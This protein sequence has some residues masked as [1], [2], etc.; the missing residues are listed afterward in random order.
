MHRRNLI[1]YVAALGGDVEIQV[2][3]RDRVVRLTQFG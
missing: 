2:R 3:M 1:A